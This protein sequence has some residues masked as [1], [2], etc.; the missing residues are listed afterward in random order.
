MSIQTNVAVTRVKTKLGSIYEEVRE[1]AAEMDALGVEND[2]LIERS[3]GAMAIAE[4]DEGHE[5][6]PR[7]CP[8]L[9]AVSELRRTAE[10]LANDLV[11]TLSRMRTVETAANE[12]L[13]TYM[14]KFS[15][16]RAV[17]DCLVA[18][19]AAVS[20]VKTTPLRPRAPCV[21]CGRS[22]EEHKGTDFYGHAWR[23]SI[24]VEPAL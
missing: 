21:Q 19:A 13:R 18:L 8:M 17:D 22:F 12:V 6:V 5:K 7:D 11:S 16:S 9:V 14:P 20:G 10:S 15:D 4:G 2:R 23:E 3:V 24:A 1:L